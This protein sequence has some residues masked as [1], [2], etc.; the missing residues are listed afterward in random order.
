MTA[1]AALQLNAIVGIASACG[2]VTLMSMV[3]RNPVG[4][5]TAVAHRDYRDLAVAVVQHAAGWLHAVLRYL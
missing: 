3:L 1:R 5:A 4:V 2:A